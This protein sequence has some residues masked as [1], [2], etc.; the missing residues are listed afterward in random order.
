M[1]TLPVEAETVAAGL[2]L[3]ISDRRDRDLIESA[4]SDAISDVEGY[5]GRSILP[6]QYVV[7]HC[8]P[9]TGW[10]DAAWEFEPADEP[11]RSIVSAVPETVGDPP[12]ATGY[13]TVTYT[14]G[15]DCRDPDK[16]PILRYIKAA[17]MNDPTVIR[18]WQTSTN[19]RGQV[20]NVSAE[21]QAITY[22]A[23]SA[24]GG[25]TPGS[26]APGALPTLNSLDR[27]KIAGRRI[28][29]RRTY[30]RQ[31]WPYGGPLW[32]C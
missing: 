16:A 2:G 13:Y 27:W 5:L 6:R 31:P 25:G 7:Q 1:T 19:T 12:V 20:M 9:L 8:W 14:A 3:N 17:A 32:D 24:G 30:D 29:Q 23:L 4:I 28:Y 21:G 22:Q 15:L 10:G 18:M 26:Q 11:V